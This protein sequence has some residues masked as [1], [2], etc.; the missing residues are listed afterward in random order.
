MTLNP[1]TIKW[2]IIFKDDKFIDWIHGTNQENLISKLSLKKG[3]SAYIIT[4][5]QFG[6]I[7]MSYKD[8]T[9]QT[10]LNTVVLKDSFCT[11]YIPVTSKQLN[12]RID[13]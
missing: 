5:K 11:R 6:M 4:D 3:Q 10:P 13:A 12:N 1:Y 7:Q 2:A 8:E 9:K